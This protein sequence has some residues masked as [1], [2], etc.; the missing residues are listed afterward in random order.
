[1][2]K[3]TTLLPI[4]AGL[5]LSLLVSP[6]LADE[7]NFQAGD[8]RGYN[9]TSSSIN[10]FSVN[11]Y[12]GARTRPYS[13]S[14]AVCCAVLPAKWRPGVI[15]EVTWEADPNPFVDTP[16]L[17]TKEFRAFMVEHKK[18][19]R[20]LSAMVE[21]PPYEDQVCAMQVHF[22]PCDEIKIS[23]SCWKYPSPKN[24]IKEPPEM[25]EPATCAKP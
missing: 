11:G 19:Y 12:G 7:P 4:S 2:N 1:M 22:L 5:V 25:K 14:G 9:H 24:P 21:L 10:Y 20:R 13:E 18:N 16:P 23:T 17:G 3:Q 6:C 15:M 8:V